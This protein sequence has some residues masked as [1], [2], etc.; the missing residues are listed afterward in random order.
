MPGDKESRENL[1]KS[2][3]HTN[4]K[5]SS[6]APVSNQDSSPQSGDTGDSSGTSGDGGGGES[7]QSGESNS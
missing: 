2:Y 7:D 6:S 5:P 3:T 1:E 4:P